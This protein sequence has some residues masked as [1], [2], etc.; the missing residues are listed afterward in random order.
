MASPYEYLINEDG[1]VVLIIRGWLPTQET[2]ERLSKLQLVDPK[3]HVTQEELW[4]A[5]EKE[6]EWEQH[7]VATPGGVKDEPHLV[8]ACGDSELKHHRYAG[9]TT[10]P[11]HPWNPSI[12]RIRDRIYRESGL[13]CNSCLPSKYRYLSD[14]VGFHSDKECQPPH[15]VVISVSLGQT[16]TFVFQ[17]ISDKVQFSTELRTGDMCIMWGQTQELFK[18]SIIKEHKGSA[19][20]DIDPHYGG[21]RYVLTF[22][23]LG[24]QNL[25]N[26]SKG[27]ALVPTPKKS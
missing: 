18:H 26:P 11:M 21:V 17:R 10:V 13:Y 9:K 8:Y 15:N 2:V 27:P 19:R 3:D 14:S 24:G 5:C 25:K 7:Q 6:I 22:R 1:C 20:R 12:Q 16:R 4:Q 23:Q